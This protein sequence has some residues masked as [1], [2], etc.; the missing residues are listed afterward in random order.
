[1]ACNYP[2]PAYKLSNGEIVFEERKGDVRQVLRLPC[3][4]C[5]GCRLERSRQWA[6][7]CMHE[8]QMHE[9]NCF[10]T[11]TYNDDHLPFDNSLDY[12]DFQKFMKRLRKKFSYKVKRGQQG[13]IG[14]RPIKFFMCGE[15]GDEL[16][17]PHF[18]ACIFGID[19]DD[20]VYFKSSASGSKLYTSQSLQN[21]WSDKGGYPIGHVTV[22]DVS[23][24]S[25]GYVA[26]YI[27]KKRLGR[28]GREYKSID[29]ETGEVIDKQ[30]EF[31]RMSLRQ[32]IGHSFYKKWKTDI[33]PEDICVVNGV[34][35]KPPKYYAKKLKEED[36]ELYEEI[37]YQ[38]HRRAMKNSK[39]N[40]EER[41]LAKEKVLKSKIKF[42]KREI[43]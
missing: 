10:I 43:H 42:L 5:D 23:F 20:R 8:A 16:G 34:A 6:M 11:L 33:Y 39:D 2:I 36:P 30:P 31:A 13:P 17:R 18:H 3:G 21:L 35:Q 29:M 37:Q 15:Y 28:T 41:L 9:Q 7:R 19:F 38:K 22:G 32:G 4:Q 12:T 14:F 26:R 24:A 27:M 25:A 1:M 40:T